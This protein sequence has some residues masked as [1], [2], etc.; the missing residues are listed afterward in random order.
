MGLLT[1]NSIVQE[2][3]P[4]PMENRFFQ[5][6]IN[7]DFP[8]PKVNDFLYVTPIVQRIFRETLNRARLVLLECGLRNGILLKI[9]SL[10]W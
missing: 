4:V 5:I 2:R 1:H 7:V 3:Q 10:T 6:M 8:E 9:I